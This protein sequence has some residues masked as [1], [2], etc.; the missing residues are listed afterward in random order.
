MP[1]CYTIP[2]HCNTMSPAFLSLFNFLPLGARNR[3]ATNTSTTPS[4]PSSSSSTPQRSP[5]VP[6]RTQG[7]QQQPPQQQ[8]SSKPH[9]KRRHK[10]SAKNKL[11]FAICQTPDS[12]AS[13]SGSAS[14]ATQQGSRRKLS[15]S[16][17][18]AQIGRT[19]AAIARVASSCSTRSA[20]VPSSSLQDGRCFDVSVASLSPVR[21]SPHVER[22]DGPMVS[23]SSRSS[24]ACLS[25]PG[26]DSKVT[27][28]CT[29]P[30]SATPIPLPFTAP[31][32]YFP[33]AASST[34]R[35]PSIPSSNAPST[36]SCVENGLRNN[37]SSM[38]PFADTVGQRQQRSMHLQQLQQRI[39]HCE[40]EQQTQ[41]QKHEERQE[42]W[43]EALM[44]SSTT[45]GQAKAAEELKND[46]SPFFHQH[47]HAELHRPQDI[48]GH[49]HRDAQQQQQH[50]GQP[51]QGQEQ[52]AQQKQRWHNYSEGHQP[53]QDTGL[54][55][56][57]R[58]QH[59]EGARGERLSCASYIL[60]ANLVSPF[61]P[62]P[63]Q[64]PTP[65]PYMPA[66]NYFTLPDNDKAPRSSIKTYRGE[67]GPQDPT[68]RFEILER[69]GY[70]SSGSSVFKACDRQDGMKIVA[71][72]KIPF[73]TFIDGFRDTTVSSSSN[74]IVDI[75][76]VVATRADVDYYVSC[77]AYHGGSLY[78]G[79]DDD[80]NHEEEYN[81]DDDDGSI[82]LDSG[83]VNK[84]R[85]PQTTAPW[86]RERVR[87]LDQLVKCMGCHRTDTELW[88]SFQENM[89]KS[90]S[91]GL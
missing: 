86:I 87:G 49:E 58:V 60:D 4:S 23:S 5:T 10:D 53:R 81:S 50:Q 68:A 22:H 80:N 79:G 64:T 9:R 21:E 27:T 57:S 82:I 46:H 2:N 77:I 44:T 52:R 85:R 7:H 51:H 32:R 38:Q 37:N 62:S 8:S 30:P 48:N 28:E 83:P 76:R 36:Y 39:E 25:T 33:S 61:S 75:D 89:S 90:Y 12:I 19:T 18:K 41:Q 14:D 70:G 55:L 20:S 35:S 88:V 74:G 43:T 67:T 13:R 78:E 6:A 54:C 1:P 40:Q 66:L 65:S 47:C 59:E 29:V 16:L 3:T 56:T 91:V 73:A 72:K 71:I 34:S 17:L 42:E 24:A 11:R 45:S 84:A 69:L 31:A 26:I 15:I 63:L